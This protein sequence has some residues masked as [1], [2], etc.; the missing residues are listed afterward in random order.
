MSTT[1]YLQQEPFRLDLLLP[2]ELEALL[3]EA[4]RIKN[5]SLDDF[6]L[7]ALEKTAQATLENHQVIELSLRDRDLFLAALD[8]D[9]EPNEALRR[10]MQRHQ[11][12]IQP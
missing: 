11:E 8:E 2:P 12:M 3:V 1:S 9:S 10:A 5:A 7:W 4:A 6:V